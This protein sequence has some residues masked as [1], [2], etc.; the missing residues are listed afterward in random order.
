[1]TFEFDIYKSGMESDGIPNTIDATSHLKRN[2]CARLIR[3]I[4]Y[5]P[6]THITKETLINYN[7][8]SKYM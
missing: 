1:M 4:C 8:A 3:K 7:F 5:S 6:W 2:G